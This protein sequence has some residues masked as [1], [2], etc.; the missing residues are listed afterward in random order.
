MMSDSQI[1]DIQVRTTGPCPIQGSLGLT[2]I[3]NSSGIKV[4]ANTQYKASFYY[5]F[6]TSSRFS[7]TLK[8]GLQ[9]DGGIML[10]MQSV[11]ITGSQ[12]TWKKV[13]VSLHADITTESTANMFTITVDGNFAVKKNI[14][15]AMLS[16][17]PPTFKNRE[18]GMR[19]DIAE[20]CHTMDD[21]LS[22]MG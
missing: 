15:F 21:E 2:T 18:N 4:T 16:L 7:G 11:G 3:F 20:V 22:S 8:I 5:R 1:R 12:T 6:Q 17:F 10:A 13:Q 19:V 9:G 14:N